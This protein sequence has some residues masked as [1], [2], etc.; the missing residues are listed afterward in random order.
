MRK[1]LTRILGCG[2]AAVALP[3][4]AT[5]QI[6]WLEYTRDDSRISDPNNLVLGDTEEK[7]Y[8]WGDLDKDGW[9]DLV[10]VR[11]QPYTTQGRRKN[12]LL[13]NEGGTLV[14][15]TSLYASASDVSGDNGFMTK[16]NDRDVV[17]ADVDG[18]GWLD[19]VTSTTLSPG[20]PKHISHPRVYMNL[21]N[22]ANGNWLGL[23]F[24]AART[25]QIKLIGSGQDYFPFFCGVG[26]GDVT[27]NGVPDLYFA[28]YDVAGYSDVND[29]LFIND[30]TG[31]FSDESTARMSSSMLNSPFGT[32]AAIVDMNLDG[33][34]D[35]IKNTGLGNTSGNPLVAISYNN[36]SNQGYF[37]ILQQPYQGS[38]YHVSVG[39]LNQDARPDMV[40]SDDGN[41]RYM[42]NNGVDAL[43]RVT[44]SS[45]FTYVVNDDGFGSNS[46]IS[47]LDND[48]WPEV[49]IA[50]VDVNIPGCSRRMHIYHNKGGTIGGNITLKEESGSGYRG[51]S[52][53]T[54]SDLKGTHDVAALDID[55][56]GDLD[57]VIG[58]CTG[59]QVW[60]NKLIDGTP[61]GTNYC[62]PAVPNSSGLS[63]VISAM[64]SEQV[65]QNNV[66]LTAAGLPSNQFGYFLT[67]QTS[68]F[69][70]NPGG[71][72]G[73]LCLG[74]TMGRYSA[75][76]QNSGGAGEFSLQID[77][78]NM[79]G[80]V[81][82][83]VNPGETWYFTAWFRDVG[84]TS[85]F[86]DGIQIDFL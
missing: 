85:N 30:G 77:L 11:K 81:Q 69:I 29:R 75:F 8:A 79:P 61:I 37:N 40:I 46:L 59:T 51:V 80:P 47:D 76:V 82:T 44:W 65:S 23:R 17:F 25:P 67:S 34:N 58:R 18:D 33:V 28:D 66:T 78:T 12:V 15:R 36:P 24:E 26:A 48:G 6:S 68:G 9:T 7:D 50:D 86:T 31:F 52:G 64:G 70:A 41:D 73:N 19:V 54:A 72:Q 56:D 27:G 83:V 74:G 45:A 35:I 57:L 71:S 42:L 5:A 55:N 43:G 20:Q 39:D 2:I 13:M 21:G 14:D 63:A 53:I 62:G 22:D 49:L 3:S 4:L 38:P 32:S 84:S 1:P 16:T 10:I 60:M